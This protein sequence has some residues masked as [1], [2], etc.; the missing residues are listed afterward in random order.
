[1]IS[2][3]RLLSLLTLLS[4][5]CQA[6]DPTSPPTPTVNADVWGGCVDPE[7]RG[8]LV[9]IGQKTTVCLVIGDGVDWQK[10]RTYMRLHFQPI[11]DDYSRFHVP[12]SFNNLMIE[13]SAPRVFEIFGNKNITVHAASQSALSFQK[14]YSDGFAKIYPHLT[15][16]IDVKDGVVKGIAWDDACIFCGKGTCEDNT[17]DFNGNLGNAE[18]FGQ[19][20]GGCY[21][22]EDECIESVTA[23]GTDCDLLL[24]V[25]WTGTDANGLAFQ[26][27]SYRFS[28][29]P[30]QELS[31]RF[32]QNLP[33]L[34][35]ID[36]PDI[37][38]TG[39]GEEGAGTEGN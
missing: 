2:A 21:L 27:S 38:F 36:L 18:D 22:K 34:P 1:M 10:Q 25:V 14:R 17:F 13:G 8:A 3:T 37:P 11:A 9:T 4:W 33:D 29:F 6:Q 23:G 26:S 39:G 30:A 16:I 32:S 24:Y 20:V 28:A 19:P 35:S 5:H 15:A 12:R 7:N 31:D